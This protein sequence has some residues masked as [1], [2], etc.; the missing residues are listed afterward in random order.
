MVTLLP[1]AAITVPCTRWPIWP[2]PKPPPPKPPRPPPWPPP[3]RPCATACTCDP[4][5]SKPAATTT[6]IQKIRRIEQFLPPHCI[7]KFGGNLLV[8]TGVS[9]QRTRRRRINFRTIPNRGIRSVQ[10]CRCSR[11]RASCVTLPPCM[12]S[13]THP[14]AI[15]I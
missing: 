3:P 5:T 9:A 13:P 15:H 7:Q 6:L 8:Q 2:P 14:T 4:E 12:T 1:V 11:L 10:F